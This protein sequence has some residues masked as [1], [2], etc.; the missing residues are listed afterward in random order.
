M[1]IHPLRSLTKEIAAMLLHLRCPRGL[2]VAGDASAR[3]SERIFVAV[4]EADQV[5]DPL[6]C[7]L[8][9]AAAA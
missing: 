6:A 1:M 9:G 7:H 8:A 2:G 3:A 4:P 5:S